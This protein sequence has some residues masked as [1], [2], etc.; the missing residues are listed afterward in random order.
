MLPRT[1][2]KSLCAWDN[3]CVSLLRVACARA[4]EPTVASLTLR[5]EFE[6]ALACTSTVGD[7]GGGDQWRAE[8]GVATFGVALR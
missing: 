5:I 1:S 6:A 4:S 2:S 3:V 7:R 8:C